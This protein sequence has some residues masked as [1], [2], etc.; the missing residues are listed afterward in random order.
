MK[1]ISFLQNIQR[2]NEQINLFK[3]NFKVLNNHTNSIYHLSK[4]KDGRLV[5]CSDDYTLNI[6]KKDTFEL[7]LSIKEHSSNIRYFTQLKNDKIITCSDDY[8]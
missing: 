3:N 8:S 7:Q 1:Y 4:L 2:N 6:Y 5:S